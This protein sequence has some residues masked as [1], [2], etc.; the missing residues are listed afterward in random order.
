MILVTMKKS[1]PKQPKR[2]VGTNVANKETPI[3]FHDET[4]SQ[5]AASKVSSPQASEYKLG[6]SKVKD[7]EESVKYEMGE[8]LTASDGRGK[9]IDKS[10]KESAVVVNM[11]PSQT[12]SPTMTV[13]SSAPSKKSSKSCS[14]NNIC[15]LF[16]NRGKSTGSLK[17]SGSKISS[18]RTGSKLSSGSRE[19][20][21]SK[22]SRPASAAS[23]G[24]KPP[25][26]TGFDLT[27]KETP[28]KK[29]H[30]LRRL[31]QKRRQKRFIKVIQ[32]K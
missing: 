18:S 3:G 19:G 13:K 2:A 5:P 26:S 29:D 32:I 16:G 7:G 21:R 4:D 25:S 8:K 11:A 28:S 12:E 6:V 10:K 30:R 24:S 31:H 27:T 9:V 22:K 20:I 14:L 17:S 15:S 23:L 1:K